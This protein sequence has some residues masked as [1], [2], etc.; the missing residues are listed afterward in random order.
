MG[1]GIFFQE[2]PP[3]TSFWAL[4]PL[5]ATK[6]RGF[7]QSLGVKETHTPK[8]GCRFTPWNEASEF[9]PESR[10]DLKR[11]RSYSN[12]PFSGANCL[13]FGGVGVLYFLL[14][15]F[16]VPKV[17]WAYNL[18]SKLLRLPRPQLALPRQ[19]FGGVSLLNRGHININPVNLTVPLVVTKRKL[20]QPGAPHCK[21]AASTPYCWQKESWTIWDV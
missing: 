8:R 15:G 16:V 7:I 18:F 2:L 14:R 21:F 19:F 9:T 12:H 3:W 5:K 13:F 10:P 20:Q 1:M 11:K 17:D 4:K 6:M